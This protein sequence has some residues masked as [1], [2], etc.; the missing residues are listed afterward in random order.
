MT[1]LTKFQT[2][3]KVII[4]YNLIGPLLDSD[5]F[6]VMSQ[7]SLKKKENRVKRKHMIT[8]PMR[9]NLYLIQWIQTKI[10][11]QTTFH[12]SFFSKLLPFQ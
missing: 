2:Y 9:T 5:A 1:P 10:L 3:F 6:F 12:L 8:S 7:S 11:A 4:I